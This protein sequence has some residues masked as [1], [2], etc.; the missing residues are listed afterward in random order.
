MEV[1]Y[2]DHIQIRIVWIYGPKRFFTTY[3]KKV[4]SASGILELTV[5]NTTKDQQICNIINSRVIFSEGY[6]QR[7]GSFLWKRNEK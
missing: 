1:D 7:C 6:R 2:L 5:H 4:N 3:P